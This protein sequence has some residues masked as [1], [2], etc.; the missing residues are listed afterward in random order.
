MFPVYLKKKEEEE[1]KENVYLLRGYLCTTSS[2]AS[3]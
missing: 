1:K 3:I 2:T